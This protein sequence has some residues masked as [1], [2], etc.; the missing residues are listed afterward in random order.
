[1]SRLFVTEKEINFFNDLSKELIKDIVGVHIF[2]YSISIDKTKIHPIYEEA[3]DKIFENPIKLECLV[4]FIAAEPRSTIFGQ[5]EFSSVNV[6]LHP[7]DLLDKGIDF[8]IGDFFSFGPRFFEATSVIQDQIYFGQIEHKASVKVTGR[9]ARKS[10]FITK[11]L[12]PTDEKYNDPDA[13]QTTFHQTR[14]DAMNAEGET[15]DVRELRKAG[16]LERNIN[17]PAQISLEND[18][19]RSGFYGDKDE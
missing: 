5:E 17:G 9:E 18:G 19:V 12:G 13:V 15:G 14:G 2:Y 11:I 10:Q 3:V 16:V 4:E 6:Y 8:Q 7:R 1:M